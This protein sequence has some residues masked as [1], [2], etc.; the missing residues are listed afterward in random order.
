MKKRKSRTRDFG[1]A[2]FDCPYCSGDLLIDIRIRYGAQSA[3]VSVVRSD[4]P[5]PSLQ[6]PPLTREDLAK[7]M[8]ATIGSSLEPP[9]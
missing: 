4:G 1:T 7:A 9:R 2:H 8:D 6:G 5:E 3:L